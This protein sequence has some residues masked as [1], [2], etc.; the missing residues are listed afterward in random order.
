MREIAYLCTRSDY[1]K[2]SNRNRV[3]H[4][5]ANSSFSWYRHT[6]KFKQYTTYGEAYAELY[7]TE[8]G[9]TYENFRNNITD[10]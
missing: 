2:Q 1:I 10:I 5:L 7:V 3:R 9:L 8:K 6:T 4:L